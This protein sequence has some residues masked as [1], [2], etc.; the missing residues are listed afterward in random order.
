MNNDFKREDI[1]FPD[2]LGPSKFGKVTRPVNKVTGQKI[3]VKEY[4][5]IN[6]QSNKEDFLYEYIALKAIDHPNTIKIY[7]E[8]Q[9]KDSVHGSR[10]IIE[11]ASR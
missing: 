9:R 10:L 6:N 3:A 8:I 4:S 7:G 5:D 1:E 11:F 2:E